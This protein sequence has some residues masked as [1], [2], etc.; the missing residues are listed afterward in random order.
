MN[1]CWV[2]MAACLLA[3]FTI[4]L[5]SESLVCSLGSCAFLLR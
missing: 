4:W 2:L 5:M 1:L 3:I